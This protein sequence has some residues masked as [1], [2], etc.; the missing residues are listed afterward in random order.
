MQIKTL[1]KR[2]VPVG[3]TMA[4]LT[5]AAMAIPTETPKVGA[6][7]WIASLTPDALKNLLTPDQ[8]AA[9]PQEYR[10][11]LSRAL[12]MPE[13][14]VAF[15]K[16][17]LDNYR[18]THELSPVQSEVLEKV[19]GLITPSLFDERSDAKVARRLITEAHTAVV[20]A[21]GRDAADA[22][23]RAAGTHNADGSPLTLAEQIRHMWRTHRPESVVALLHSAVPTL[24]AY[25]CNCADNGDCYYSQ[26]CNQQLS[27]D[28]PPLPPFPPYGCGS[29]NWYPCSWLCSY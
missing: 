27:C 20:A 24:E 10:R 8:I 1:A 18:R 26:H 11:A 21:L 14:R 4:G 23:F 9:L 7:R 5:V 2:A 16:G 22:I 28:A 17:V 13:S 19:E 15:W 29:W 12:Q 25:V 6:E 3:A